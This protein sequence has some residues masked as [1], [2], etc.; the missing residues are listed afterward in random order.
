MDYMI[1]MS[2]V[3]IAAS[4]AGVTD[5]WRFKVYNFVTIPLILTGVAYHG[6]MSGAPGLAYSLTGLLFGFFMLLLPYMLG[7]IGAGDVKLLAGI[8]AWLGARD[9][10]AVFIVASAFTAA[11]AVY[12]MV[13]HGGVRRSFATLQVLLFQLSTVGKHLGAE[14]SVQAVMGQDDRRKH[15]IPFATMV[16]VGVIAIVIWGQWG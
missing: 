16:A 14:E 12:L 6:F 3:C 7:A 13:R 1:P 9:A 5:A 11:Y 2:V 15:L 8:G 10:T 4:I